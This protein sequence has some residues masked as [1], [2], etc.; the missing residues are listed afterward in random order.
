VATSLFL[1]GNAVPWSSLAAV[2]AAA[3]AVPLIEEL[4][5]RG[6]LL[7]ILLRSARP[8]VATLTTA[9]FFAIVHFLKAPSRSNESVTWLS[10]FHSIANSFAQFADPMMVLAGLDRKSV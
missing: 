7:G 9:G 8:V 2:L 4:F 5:F 6:L 3:I 1:L 10:G